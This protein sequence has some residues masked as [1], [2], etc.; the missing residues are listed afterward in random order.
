MEPQ[1]KKKV[2]YFLTS[3]RRGREDVSHTLCELQELGDVAVVGGMLRDIALFGNAGFRSDVDLVINVVDI[4]LFERLM[5]SINAK[6]NR[7][8]GYSL[9][10]SKWQIDVWP[11]SKTWAHVSGYVKV[12]SLEDISEVTFF[13]CDAILYDLQKRQI[14][15]KNGYFEHLNQRVLDINLEPNP[16]PVGN[17]VRAF[18]YSILKGFRWAPQLTNFVAYTIEKEGWNRLFESEMKSFRTRHIES[19]C[20]KSFSSRINTNLSSSQIDLFDPRDFQLQKQLKLPL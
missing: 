18:R 1:L 10:Y 3:K 4:D 9:P 5:R 7:F 12:T 20:R 17:A 13:D 2:E 19:L 8:G 16:N 6:V 15:T 14:K 11:L